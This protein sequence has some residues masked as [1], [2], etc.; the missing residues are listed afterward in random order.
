MSQLNQQVAE[1]FEALQAKNGGQVFTLAERLQILSFAVGAKAYSATSFKAVMHLGLAATSAFKAADEWRNQ[2]TNL[3]PTERV[4][5]AID[6]LT[7]AY[8]RIGE[9]EKLHGAGHPD[10]EDD[11]EVIDNGAI[12][13]LTTERDAAR[14]RVTELETQN[15]T[16]TA[17]RDALVASRATAEEIARRQLNK[18]G[19]PS[20]LGAD[21]NG[22]K[23]D[24]SKMTLTERAQA[25]IDAKQGGVR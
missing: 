18:V 4:Q 12:T 14:A 10:D 22:G 21:T 7:L 11:D 1:A 24:E 17:E 5:Q 9:L 2:H 25:A 20:P 15:R 3:S 8:A 23:K 13:A 16:L 6:D 19:Q